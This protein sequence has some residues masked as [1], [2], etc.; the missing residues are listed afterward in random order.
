MERVVPSL[1]WL[2]LLSDSYLLSHSFHILLRVLIH[3]FQDNELDTDLSYNS[4]LI[5]FFTVGPTI[6]A[7]LLLQVCEADISAWDQAL[8]GQISDHIQSVSAAFAQA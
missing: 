1:T 5:D 8:I 7:A 4:W 2:F 3:S 6:Q